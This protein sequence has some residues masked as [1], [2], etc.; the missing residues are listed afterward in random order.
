MAVRTRTKG[1]SL[2]TFKG[3][4][5]ENEEQA[6]QDIKLFIESISDD[7]SHDNEYACEKAYSILTNFTIE[8][9]N[10]AEKTLPL[11]KEV[12]MKSGGM[13]TQYYWGYPFNKLSEL[14]EKVPD[15]IKPLVLNAFKEVRDTPIAEKNTTAKR[16]ALSKL[17]SMFKVD[18][19]HNEQIIDILTHIN[20]NDRTRA[21]L[22]VPSA[23]VPQFAQEMLDIATKSSQA[24]LAL[25]IATLCPDM[26]DKALDVFD[27]INNNSDKI[28]HFY[29]EI[30]KAILNKPEL[31][32]RLLKSYKILFSKPNEYKMGLDGFIYLSKIAE[33]QPLF[34]EEIYDI[35]C[36][37]LKNPSIDDDCQKKYAYSA[38]EK[39]ALSTPDLAYKVLDIFAVELQ[40]D[41]MDEKNF[42]QIIDS[43]IK[44]SELQ[45]SLNNKVFELSK[46][47][48]DA[49]ESYASSRLMSKCIQNNPNLANSAIEVLEKNS[50]ET[51]GSLIATHRVINTIASANENVSLE[52]LRILKKTLKSPYNDS[53]TLEPTYKAL[54]TISKNNPK[55]TKDA[56]SLYKSSL[57]G[58]VSDSELR[59]GYRFATDILLNSPEYTSG[60]IDLFNTALMSTSSRIYEDDTF[61]FAYK[62]L[63]QLIKERPNLQQELFDSFKLGLQNKRNNAASL[64]T[65]YEQLALILD[66]QPQLA[67][68]CVE[69]IDIGVQSSKN[70]FYS[71]QRATEILKYIAKD[72]P[73]LASDILNTSKHLTK[74]HNLPLYK[75]CMKHLPLEETIAKHP[76][77]EQDLRV[78][79]KARF[80]NDHEFEYALGNYDKETLIETNIFSA[81]QRV[82]NILF[83]TSAQEAG[84]SKEDALNFRKPDAPNAVTDYMASNQDWLIPASFKGAAIFKEYFPA[85]IK[86]IQNHNQ[87]NPEDKISIHDAVYWLPEPMNKEAN[88]RF[89]KFIQRNIV[90]QNAEHKNVHRPFNELAMISRNWQAVEKKLAQA[91]E[92]SDITKLKYNDI[93]SICM[94]VRYE[95]QRNDAFAVE[96]AKHGVPEENYH[97]CEDIY[98]AGL[99]VP[100]PFDSKKEFKEGKYTGRFLP[101]DDVRTGFFGDY[102]DCCQHFGGVGDA[103]AVSTVKHPFSQ[104]F[105]IE[106]EKGKIV[107]G[108]WAWENTEGKYRE[109]CFDNIEAIGEFSEHPMVNKI[110]GQ[111]GDYLAKEQNCRKVTIGLGYQDADVTEYKATESIKLPKLYGNDGTDDYSDSY[112]QVLLAENPNAKPLDKTQ[113]SQRYIRDVCFLDMSAMDRVSEVVFPDGDKQLQAPENMAGFVVEDREKGVVGYCLYDKEKKSIY[114]MAVLPEYRKDKNASSRKLFAEMMRVINKEGGEWSAEMRDETTLRY[115]KVMA[116]RGLV[117]YEEHGVDH[118]MSDGTKVVAVTFSPVSEKVRQLK[119]RIEKNNNGN[120]EKT[121]L[122]SNA[123]TK[124]E[125]SEV[126]RN[127]SNNVLSNAQSNVLGA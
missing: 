103:C 16:V 74:D 78:A 68:K 127:K 46:S 90:Y 123:S 85:Y 89:S 12:A 126:K 10:L 36:T 67:K 66:S 29:D 88:A 96:A 112:S 15:N 76:E 50:T 5:K 24:T 124:S 104:L 122:E 53:Y 41:K 48:Y 120:N 6:V 65:A 38:L 92:N 11:F 52:I 2:D 115:L 84:I 109:V 80:A 28:G 99:K 91:D 107:A 110:Y 69:V 87:K 32:E 51:Q 86:T 58:Y 63:S 100:E 101:R 62:C 14:M 108:S 9:P 81:Q 37:G 20:G 21:L 23:I 43:I 33:E 26:T 95:D 121:E 106:D 70:E 18:S 19:P 57:H 105:V 49:N 59:Q 1:I 54:Q 119:Q 39:V 17:T 8:H 93:L 42:K 35:I 77:I 40:S 13:G 83:S 60:A 97:N 4:K 94:S 64:D 7:W 111:V 30:S 102:T 116:E 73:E 27:N 3:I 98:L 75:A 113:E 55:L 47:L 45:P 117:S 118:V 114:D 79:H 22:Y 71:L 72:H 125:N 82:M 31:T 34:H 61:K 25:T 56:L 44:I